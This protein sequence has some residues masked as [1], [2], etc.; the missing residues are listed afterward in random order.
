[1]NRYLVDR[2][3]D[4]MGINTEMKAYDCL[5]TGKCDSRRTVKDQHINDTKIL[6]LFQGPCCG[7]RVDVESIYEVSVFSVD[8]IVNTRCPRCGKQYK[9]S[10]FWEDA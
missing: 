6:R 4:A 3:L 1:M 10:V 9:I 5:M 2:P 8:K 7:V